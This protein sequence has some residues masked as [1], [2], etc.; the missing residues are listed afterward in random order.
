[1]GEQPGHHEPARPAVPQ[2]ESTI[3][4]DAVVLIRQVDQRDTPEWCGADRDLADA[5][6]VENRVELEVDDV[7]RRRREVD[8]RDDG[9]DR[10]ADDLD[11]GAVDLD[12]RGPQFGILVE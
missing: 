10:V 7:G 4:D 3:D 9:I 2:Q 12:E 5:V 6:G 11:W 8:L 1:M